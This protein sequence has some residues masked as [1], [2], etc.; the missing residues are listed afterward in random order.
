ME[1]SSFQRRRSLCS[2]A[3][4]QEFQAEVREE[5]R[6]DAPARPFGHQ[7]PATVA[8]TSVSFFEARPLHGS[9]VH[10]LAVGALAIC[11]VCFSRCEAYNPNK[12]GGGAVLG[13]NLVQQVPD[14]L[15]R[16]SRPLL[17]GPEAEVMSYPLHE[18]RQH[19]AHLV[20]VLQQVK[21]ISVG[22]VEHYLGGPIEPAEAGANH[23][24]EALEAFGLID[25]PMPLLEA[26]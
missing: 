9:G 26:V 13:V 7:A 10:H 16:S 4:A 18:W 25:L 22:A 17:N 23:G 3:W 15:E 6:A 21:V 5:W 11:A 24:W 19:Y 20:Q 12:R 14:P 1:Q 2:Q 8:A